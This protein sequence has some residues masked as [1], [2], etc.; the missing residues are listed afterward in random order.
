MSYP[1]IR[2][3]RSEKL[4]SR[5]F[6]YFLSPTEPRN[7]GNTPCQPF[8]TAYLMSSQ[9]PSVSAGSFSVQKLYTTC[10]CFAVQD[11]PFCPDVHQ[12]AATPLW[13]HINRLIPRVLESQPDGICRSTSIQ[14]PA[15]MF[16]DRGTTRP[17]QHCAD[18]TIKSPGPINLDEQILQ[19]C[20]FT[21][22]K[23]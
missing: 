20:K 10:T 22:G 19:S 3:H 5:K 13:L 2:Q 14:L 17:C 23:Q 7:R 11:R 15:Q 4:K 21:P 9:L 16:S 12:S 18:T 6:K 1:R 8:G